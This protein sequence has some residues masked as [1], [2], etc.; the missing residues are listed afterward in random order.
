MIAAL[1]GIL[2]VLIA[3][4]VGFADLAR[5]W[6]LAIAVDSFAPIV[7]AFVTLGI[8]FTFASTL[9]IVALRLGEPRGLPISLI[10]AEIVLF[11]VQARLPPFF[12]P[13]TL[14]MVGAA[15]GVLRWLGMAADPLALA[16][17]WLQLLHALS[18]GATHLGALMFLAHNAPA[19]Q[20]ATAQG[21]LAIAAGLAT[22][23][24]LSRRSVTERTAITSL[25]TC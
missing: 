9:A 6:S 11:A 21:Y 19:G 10:A 15:A 22:G 17:P 18:F 20:A 2:T 23:S 25:P 4:M 3:A 12:S 5:S 16:L 14:L 13:T 1:V 24:L 8:G 7:A